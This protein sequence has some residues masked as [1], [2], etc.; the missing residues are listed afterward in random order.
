VKY[1]YFQVRQRQISH[2]LQHFSCIFK[3]KKKQGISGIG[4][5][6]NRGN[7]GCIT[8]Y[9][10]SADA[11]KPG[12]DGFPKQ[13]YLIFEVQEEAFFSVSSVFS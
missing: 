5:D 10:M 9:I 6:R 1:I 3:Y 8:F 7:Q 13:N 4:P 2:V 12:P 11:M